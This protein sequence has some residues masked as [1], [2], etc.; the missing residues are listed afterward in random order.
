MVRFDPSD[1]ITYGFSKNFDGKL[2]RT[3]FLHN[4]SLNK[5]LRDSIYTA[6]VSKEDSLIK[7]KVLYPDG[8][9]V[10][11]KTKEIL[12]KAS[13]NSITRIIFR[14]E[15]DSLWDYNERN[16]KNMQ[17]NKD[18]KKELE[19]QFQAITKDYSFIEYHPPS[20][21]EKKPLE[22]GQKVINFEGEYI[23]NNASKYNLTNFSDHVVILDFLVQSLPTLYQVDSSVK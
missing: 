15:L 11:N 5:F 7:L 13:E 17:F 18:T 20:E 6:N 12:F 14:A 3:Y 23:P 2:L 8:G 10:I 4:T 22:I 9:V 16:L 1:H 21:K 19:E